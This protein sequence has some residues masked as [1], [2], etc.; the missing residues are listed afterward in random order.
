M[1]LVLIIRV[2]STLA[3]SGVYKSGYGGPEGGT[4]ASPAESSKAA[5]HSFL[6]L[7]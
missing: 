7:G 2:I 4:Y 3:L 5:G 1:P 6:R